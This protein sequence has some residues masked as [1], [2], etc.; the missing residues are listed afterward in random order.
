[1][2]TLPDSATLANITRAQ[3]LRGRPPTDRFAQFENLREMLIGLLSPKQL[4]RSRKAAAE[5]TGGDAA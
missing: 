5:A 4:L 1:M 2:E 3:T